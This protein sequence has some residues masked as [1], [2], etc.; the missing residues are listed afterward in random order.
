MKEKQI[1][2][3]GRCEFNINNF[4][5]IRVPAPRAC[6]VT[7]L[8]DILQLTPYHQSLLY[9]YRRWEEM[10]AV[11]LLAVKKFRWWISEIWL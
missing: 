11:Q 8:S 10:G 9:L 3:N 5:I 6:K 2:T 7:S 1:Y 4:D